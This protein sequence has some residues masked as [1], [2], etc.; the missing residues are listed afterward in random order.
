MNK[1]FKTTPSSNVK[2][3]K[4]AKTYKTRNMHYIRNEMIK[5]QR[6]RK[7][8]DRVRVGSIILGSCF[9]IATL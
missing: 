2:V 4:G 8:N 1:M 5:L 3:N 7:L 6:F 9:L